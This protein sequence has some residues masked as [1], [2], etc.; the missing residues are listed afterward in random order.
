MA[1]LERTTD[2]L[3][4][5]TKMMDNIII[6]NTSITQDRLDEVKKLRIDWYISAEEAVIWDIGEIVGSEAV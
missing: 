3:K 2:E 1:N 4:R 5:L 6:N